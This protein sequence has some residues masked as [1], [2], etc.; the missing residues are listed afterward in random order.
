MKIKWLIQDVGMRVSQ[1]HRKF[2]ALQFLGEDM[3]AIGVIP[4]YNYISGLG[5]ALDEDPNT[6]YILLSGVKVL[7]LL[8]AA[9]SIADVVEFPTE[10]QIM[11][12]DQI[13]K[14][15]IDGVFY[16]FD[17]FDQANYGKLYLPLLNKDAFYIPVKD[18]LK[19]F[20]D[21]DK[22]VKPSR[23]LKAFDAGILK[24]GMTIEAFIMSK[25][26]QRFFMEELLVVSPVRVV[27]DEYRFF[28]VNKEVITGSAYRRNQIAGEDVFVPDLIWK[29]AIEYAKLY[30]PHDVFTMDLA[31]TDDGE[32]TIIEYNCFNCSGVYLCDMVEMFKR[33]RKYIEEK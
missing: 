10:K 2:D 18:N 1:L 3:A 12:G 9:K 28:V 22:F 24:E 15:L 17:N 25:S 7:N 19:T 27:L 8:K 20:F 32:I 16:D 14:N 30:Q 5:E 29:K 21:E 33:L 26:R 11:H 6:K 31:L 4:D 13:L 23:D